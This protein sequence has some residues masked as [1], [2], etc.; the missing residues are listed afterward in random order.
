MLF[1][2]FD[3]W[4]RLAITD[5]VYS[6]SPTIKAKNSAT[7]SMNFA[8]AQQIRTQAAINLKAFNLLCIASPFKLQPAD[9]LDRCACPVKFWPMRVFQHL[10]SPQ[11]ALN[12]LRGFH[13]EAK[14]D[15]FGRLLRHGWIARHV[16]SCR[17]TH[18][19][20]SLF[21]SWRMAVWVVA[22]WSPHSEEI[23]GRMS[24]AHHAAQ[25][26]EKRTGAG[27]RPVF[28]PCL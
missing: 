9:W 11:Y 6:S 25:Q 26:V 3:F 7:L 28:T 4:L 20:C 24:A 17:W 13:A 19:I 2:F 14:H 23:R 8:T 10:T 22:C 15:F 27:L 5:I 12:W 21:P 16:W 1:Y 18:P